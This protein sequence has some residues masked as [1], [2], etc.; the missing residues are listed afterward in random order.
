[1]SDQ[2]N[3]LVTEDDEA[4]FLLLETHLRKQGLKARC[5]QSASYE[6]LKA[7]LDEG[8]WDA[9]L[10]DYSVPG[11]DFR[12]TLALIRS[13]LPDVPIILVSGSLG[14]E[15]AVELLKQGLWDF[16][17]KDNLTRLV[18][19]LQ[20]GLREAAE[21]RARRAA[22][23]ALDESQVT[24]Q[25]FYDSSPFMMGVAELHGDEIVAVHGN[26]AVA[27]FFGI[28]IEMIPDRTGTDLGVP[29]DVN[30]LWTDRC[31]RSQ[32]E[33]MPIRFE[34]A[35]PTPSGK[36][37][38]AATISYLGESNRGRPRF[39]FVTED[40]TE[41]RKLEEQL[42]QSQ[43]IEAIGALAGGVAHDFNNILSAIVGYSHL[44]QMK[45]QEDDPSRPYFEH[46][47]EA[48]NRAIVLTQS[49]LAFSRKQTVN[50][51]V[52]D[53]NDVIRGFE[54]FLL[55]LIRED[56]ALKTTYVEGTLSVMADKG[57]IEQMIMNLV[58]N[59]R[60]AMPNGGRLVIGTKTVRI[61]R[62]F[63]EA[64]G[65]GKLGE[66]ALVWVSDN[67]AGMDEKT[68]TRIFEP[69]FTTKEQG[70]G[71]GLGLSMAYGIVKKH[72]GFITVYSEPGEGSTFNI[73]I[74]LVRVAATIGDRKIE[75]PFAPQGGTE[76]ILVAEDD[77]ALRKLSMETLTHFGYTVI[78]AVDG[79][80]AVSR[81]IENKGEIQLII[82]DGIM[83]KKNGKE[84]FREI[85][86]MRPE[87]KC[88]FMS[89]YS[90]D[91]FTKDDVPGPET[92]FIHKPVSPADLLKHIREMLDR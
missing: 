9:V 58:T 45:I 18:P 32:G 19:A 31:R 33:G 39:S 50:L 55:R 63:I 52:I 80:D 24:L 10:S 51:A 17:L 4:D 44:A 41:H 78:G 21:S 64:H 23:R 74:P 7:A 49:L 91:I 43:K 65:Y 2:L 69:F 5:R 8:G 25:S 29:A 28:G 79:A 92:K 76:T 73:H 38:L 48:C 6:E 87:I 35:H 75:K 88:I 26:A 34:Y 85:K 89:G 86:E 57:Q 14:E 30:R 62:E 68:R 42:R 1:M 71:T 3:L 70:K 72:D 40:I 11:M 82:L 27:R 36:R 61:D 90:E 22:E 13:R 15:T 47:L 56:I 66:Y 59:A 12:E 46:I 20:R 53:L 60:D 54:K 16:V 81:F 83:P 67:G 84:A 37:W 77:A